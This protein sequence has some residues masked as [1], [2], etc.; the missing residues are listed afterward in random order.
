MDLRQLEFAVA[1]ADHGGFT[2]AARQLHVV[3]SAVSSTV[4]AL[5][6]ELG[7]V[8]FERNTR[9]VRLTA[10]GQAFLPAAREA[11][12]AARQVRTA[13][14]EASGTLH[15]TVTVGM[16]QGVSPGLHRALAQM[17][18]RH[19]QVTVRLRQASPDALQECVRDGNLDLAV[20]TPSEHQASC[21]VARQLW[22]EPMVL[23]INPADALAG[24]SPV[25]LDATEGRAFVD[26]SED[27]AVRHEVDLAYRA[28]KAKRNSRFEVNDLIAAV[29]LVEQNLG[30]SIMPASFAA[31][32]PQLLTRSIARDA[33]KWRVM[34]VHRQDGDG[35]PAVKALLDLIR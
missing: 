15:G 19:P 17:A 10:A 18:E 11:L 16:M 4:R 13:V 9:Y 8:L 28:A 24:H 7:A 20:V 12:E 31:R 14:A 2:A 35:S 26:F 34:V 32:F 33:P 1:V 29:D 5:E 27:W 25:T 21:L 6:R 22:E 30:I 3:Q 23:V